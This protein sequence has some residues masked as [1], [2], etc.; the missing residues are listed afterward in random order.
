MWSRSTERA[1]RFAEELDLPGVTVHAALEGRA[2]CD[3]ADL[4]VTV[5]PSERA[6]VQ[7]GRIAPGTHVNAMGSDAPGKQELDPMLVADAKVVVDRRARSVSIEELQGL[8]ALGL[9][10]AEDVHAELCAG[11]RVRG[12]GGRHRRR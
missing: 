2:T 11:A 7:R 12:L 3:G 10:H 6:I 8:L 1:E 5:T 4:V 9:M